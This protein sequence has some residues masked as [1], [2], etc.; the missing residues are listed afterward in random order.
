M[1]SGKVAVLYRASNYRNG[2]GLEMADLYIG[3]EKRH[4]R[5][6]KSLLCDKIPCVTKMFRGS[7]SEAATSEVTF[8]EDT[9]EAF[10]VLI[11]WVYHSRLPP[12][13]VTKNND[14]QKWTEILWDHC[15]VYAL[16]NKFCLP[17]LMDEVMDAF[18]LL[19]NVIKLRPEWLLGTYTWASDIPAFRV[20]RRICTRSMALM[21]L[22]PNSNVNLISF[23]L[24][25]FLTCFLFYCLFLICK[26]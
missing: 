3:E 25:F 7:F 18:L 6:H 5:V 16:A 17:E 14:S 11:S 1:A 2:L 20:W 19:L 8:P 4:L 22:N 24:V 9:P 15:K 23:L 13:A 26:I 12:G 10:E 21:I